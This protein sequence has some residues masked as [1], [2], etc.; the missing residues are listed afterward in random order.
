MDLHLTPRSRR[1]LVPRKGRYGSALIR[2][3]LA[4]Y[5][6]GFVLRPLGISF[7]TENLIS[8]R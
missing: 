2:P 8:I 3:N 4:H 1:L 6:S 5:F 7:S